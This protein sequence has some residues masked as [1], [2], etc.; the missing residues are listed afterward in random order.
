MALPLA[1]L[2]LAMTASC[3]SKRVVVNG[4]EMTYE[5]GAA[6]VY[7]EGKNAQKEGD[8]AT[9]KTRFR[10]VIEHFG[11]SEK[12]PDAMGELAYLASEDGG[13]PAARS[14]LERLASEHP[15]HPRGRQAKE[16]LAACDGVASIDKPI[17]TFDKDFEAARTDAERKDVA[18]KAADGSIAGGD[19]TAAVRWLLEV[20]K[21]EKDAAQ[22]KALEEEIAELIDARVSFLGV[23]QLY[24]EVGGSD[25]PKPL[26]S[27]KLGRIQYHVRDLDNAKKT[28]E[29]YLESWP[30]GPNA[31]GA[32]Q[33]IAYIE[34]RGD[35]KPKTV[36]ALL[37][38]SG[39]NR[40][41]GELGLQAIKLALEDSKIDLV[42]RDTKSDGP[43][44]AAMAEELALKEGAIAIIG[45]LFASEAE[46]A[47][48]KAQQLGV[49]LVTISVADTLP[50]IGPYVFRNGLTGKAQAEA[51][52]RWA[53][54][55]QGMRTFAILYPRHPYGEE[56]L[57]LFWD[58]VE[59]RKGEIRGVESY[60]MGDTTFAEQVKRLVARDQPQSRADYVKAKKE[61]DEQPDV[62]RKARCEEEARKTLKPIVDFEGLFIP[63]AYQNVSMISAALA[64]EDIIV[65]QDARRL[66]IIEKTLGR[67]VKPVT[68][69][70]PSAWN[71]EKLIEVSER[72]VE[73][74][75]FTEAFFTDADD[76]AVAEFVRAYQKKHG[77]TPQL[78]PE[79]LLYD[80]AKIF[81]LLIEKT[82]PENREQFRAA[83]RT[84]HDHP[85]VTGKISFAES[86]D[87]KRD[88]KLIRIKN[89]KFEELPPP[90]AEEKK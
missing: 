77:R 12:A 10:E 2:A 25:F 62:Y 79:A 86:T 76:K 5:E 17:T 56:L 42:V 47:G 23:R 61:C 4:V 64:F 65:E 29:K 33:M 32:K 54:D 88:V 53:M 15:L 16:A 14:L 13:C 83:L 18:S 49:P 66:K 84:V 6:L 46:P 22:S 67:E 39:K 70:G 7:R 36:G 90:P 69:L 30:S 26:L 68:L 37:P 43:T 21:L 44:A 9:A 87:A 85:G 51:L 19:F 20:R 81:R 28:L 58:E 8:L 89:G 72:N 1:A 34:A 52:V 71:S 27:Y 41:F 35:V 74:A 38:L 40:N 50:K 78:S 75:V 55:I 82:G 57:H 80:T 11:D 59:A 45:P 3:A 31:D 73:N 24:E 63:D 48:A 60:A